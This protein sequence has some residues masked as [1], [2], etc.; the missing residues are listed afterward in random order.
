MKVFALLQA[1]VV[2][3]AARRV[4]ASTSDPNVGE[5][6][7]FLQDTVKG[8]TDKLVGTLSPNA[9]ETASSTDQDSASGVYFAPF[10]T[11][12]P[13]EDLFKRNSSLEKIVPIINVAQEALNQPIP[14]NKWWANI[15]HVT[16]LKNLTNYAAWSNPY[17]VK[18]PRT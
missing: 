12:E 5:G 1:A 14:T 17:A 2:A 3:V 10:G 7:N 15:I 16:D 18:L 6:Y 13:S 4:A 9:P 8:A 11:D